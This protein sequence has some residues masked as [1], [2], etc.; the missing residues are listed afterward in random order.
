MTTQQMNVDQLAI[1]TI[2]TLSIDAIEK[3]NS[4]H[5]GM[6]MGSAPMAHV[7]WSRF[8]KVSPKNPSWI[9]RDRF[10]LSAGHGSM[11]L[12]SM[13]HLM[14]YG[15]SMDDLRNFRQWGSKTPGHPEFGHTPGVD[16]TTGPLGQG[17][18]M[19][20]GMAMAERHLAATY[21]KADYELINHFTYVICGDGDLMEGVSSEASSLAAH[22]K[23]GKMIVLYDS[24]DICLDGDLSQSFTEDVAARY[25]AYGWQYIRVEDGNNVDTIE[26]A[27]AE[28]RTDLDRPT[29]IEVK[30]T[31][32]FGS[33]NKG[34]S[35]SSH[36]APLG[37]DEVVLTKQAYAWEHEAFHVPQE[38]K[39]YYASLVEAGQQKEAEWNKLL[40]AY[41]KA[42]PELA[43]QFKK[44]SNGEVSEDFDADLPTYE[45]GSK[46]AT[47]AA[48]G[49]A[50]NGLAK[51]MPNLIGGSADLAHS[52]NTLIKGA[53]D[54]L[55]GSYEGRN[56]WFGVREFAMGAALNGMML[57]G[58]V[59]AFGGTFFVFSDYVRPAVR[60]SALM[61]LPT[62]YVF[63]HDSI[64]VG[65]DGP[66]HEPIE[67]LAA[68]RAMPNLTV[69]RPADAHET[70]E[71]WRYAAMSKDE[72]I[73]L[74]LTRQNL[75]IYQETKDLAREGLAKGAY[76]L[77]EASNGEPQV[78][79]IATGSEVSLC[80]EAREKLEAEGVPTRVVSMPSF[81]LFDRQPKEYR[82]SVI[83]PHVKA[84]VGVE[85]GSSLGWERYTGDHG[86]IIGINQFGA[87]APGDI[88]M[89]EYG[90]T[91]ENVVKTAQSLVK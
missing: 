1:N 3:A 46:L 12:Y 50:I 2:R 27:L 25:K 43:A 75:P 17:I 63:T 37:S 36:G 83:P 91:V 59:K 42:Y 48:S 58:G 6:P 21:N 24:N 69:L 82:D 7:L 39:E 33:P 5:P 31:I 20:V 55:P 44:A 13:L 74:A 4:G 90:F 22:L 78:V 67:H 34:G 62:T 86:A 23:L 76:V 32:G 38:V 65:E 16:A 54:F 71:A 56:L 66:T 9:D 80:M 61:K 28:A 10:V 57:H 85:M 64:A 89:K 49:N 81:N 87:S 30:T 53:G 15:V 41:E 14:D 70:N 72:P 51:R 79:L 19:A 77:K 40:S 29:L 35:S 26:K 84:R 68:F 73:V 18:A 60:L 8:M 45:I 47:R 88:I 11:L 52:N